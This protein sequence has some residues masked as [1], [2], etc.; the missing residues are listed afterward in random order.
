[1]E[2]FDTFEGETSSD[3][4]KDH[5]SRKEANS[6]QEMKKIKEEYASFITLQQH[7]AGHS[8]SALGLSTLY[9]T[10]TASE[11][12]LPGDRY[13]LIQGAIHSLCLLL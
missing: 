6:K 13:D 7:K 8:T 12:H 9:D 1:M 10:L 2:E 5:E 4:P 3:P 11:V